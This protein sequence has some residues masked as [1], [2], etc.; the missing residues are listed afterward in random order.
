MD[1]KGL[2]ALVWVLVGIGCVVALLPVASTGAVA[3]VG[4]AGA[5]LQDTPS[6]DN[7]LDSADEIH[8]DVFVHENGSATFVIGYEFEN[9]SNGDWEALRDDIEENPEAYETAQEEQWNDI[10]VEGEN[11]TDREMEISNVSVTTDTVSAP[12][13][14]G[15]VEVSFEWSKFA[16]VELNRIEAGDALE[17]FTLPS[18]TSL[19]IFSPEGYTIE[20]VEPTPEEGDGSSVFWSSDGAPFSPD[21]PSVVMIEE[22][23]TEQQSPDTRE[24]PSMPWLI[25]AAALAL[26]AIAGAAVWW[27]R[28]DRNDRTGGG[29]GDAVSPI[30]A[31]SI[32]AD[33][34]NGP[35][36]ELL[37]NEER[38]LH[39]L[40]E[41]GGR[42][43]QQEVVSELDWTEAKTSQVISGLREEEEIEVFRI[44]RENVLALPDDDE[45]DS[46]PP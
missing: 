46:Q 23:D 35:P 4:I 27:R 14:R 19:R 7:R 9:D 36:P 37:S 42:I 21:P 45:R 12:R 8:M 5:T 10:L 39:L 11:A 30:P 31:D 13:D 17:G 1:A 34:S 32:P 6:E 29:T 2:R 22:S 28:R 38:V 15:Y 20:E 3:D 41:H 40:E 16:Y 33:D 44:G 18:D 24:G 43:K 25:V 26:L